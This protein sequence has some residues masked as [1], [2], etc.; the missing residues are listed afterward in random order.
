MTDFDVL[1][2][3]LIESLHA[4]RAAEREIFAALDPGVRDATGSDGGWS[5]KDNLAHVAAWRRR[6]AAKMAALREGQPEP[7][8]PSEDLDAINAI[9]H[10]ERAGWTWDQVDAD[11]DA[12]AEALIAEVSTASDDALADPKIL[13]PVMGDGPEH[14]LVHLGSI[15]AGV[16][17]EDRVIA[18]ADL[19]GALIDRGGWPERS[20]ANARYLV[21]KARRGAHTLDG[22][23]SAR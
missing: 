7:A 15:A 22:P 14:D 4:C 5:A 12:S 20:A 2:A 3:S 13:A 23:L 18:L 1:R 19:T 16:G 8:E 9:L 11:A 10:D 21:T 17:L 6:Q